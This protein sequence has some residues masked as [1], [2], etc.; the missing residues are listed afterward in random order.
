MAFHICDVLVLS[1]GLCICIIILKAKAS[2]L[3]QGISFRSLVDTILWCARL[4]SQRF[5]LKKNYRLGQRSLVLALAALIVLITGCGPKL[6]SKDWA[7]RRSAVLRITDKAVLAKVAIEDAWPAVRKAAIL[8]LD[9]QALLAQIAMNENNPEV[10][11]AAVERLTDQSL[12]AKV[13]VASKLDRGFDVSK[14]AIEKLTDQELLAK[15]TLADDLREAAFTRLTNQLL[16]AKMEATLSSPVV[17]ANAINDLEDSDPV[18]MRIAR[19]GYTWGLA[20]SAW[21]SIARIKLSI[22]EHCIKSHFP[23]IQCAAN[24][25]NIGAI[26]SNIQGGKIAGP[27]SGEF[28]SIKLIQNGVVLAEASWATAFPKKASSIGFL[29][30]DVSGE[31]LLKK[32]LQRSEFVPEDLAE[33]FSSSIPEVRIAAAA[34]LNDQKILAKI[35]IESGDSDARET[36]VTKLSDQNLLARIA[37]NEKEHSVGQTAVEKLTDQNLLARVAAQAK[38]DMIVGRAAVEKLTDKVLLDRLA[39][40]ESIFIKDAAEARIRQLAE[41]K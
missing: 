2:N 13:V 34:N 10:A 24:V 29:R 39:R 19:D 14:A 41:K 1:F 6:D 3:A 31:D 36:A 35:A 8:K 15:L 7:E 22:Q 23:R 11:Q 20:R 28:V 38:D 26:Y 21:M 16:R 4:L 37:I 25:S 27:M 30:A 33:L 32:L 9:D 5:R 40:H 12:L 18:M 17:R